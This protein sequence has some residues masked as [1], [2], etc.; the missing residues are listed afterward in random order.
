M[1]FVDGNNYFYLKG[2]VSQCAGPE[3]CPLKIEHAPNG[4]EFVLGCGAC[5]D[6]EASGEAFD[7]NFRLEP[8]PNFQNEPQRLIG[9]VVD[10]PAQQDDL[11]ARRQQVERRNVFVNANRFLPVPVEKEDQPRP[12]F[13]PKKQVGNRIA[14]LMSR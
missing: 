8:L 2:A 10:N 9:R 14:D 1:G 7:P 13:R 5:R 12:L 4:E 3:S 11:A 6:S